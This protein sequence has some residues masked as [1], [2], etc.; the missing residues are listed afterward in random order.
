MGSLTEKKLT[1]WQKRIG[2]LKSAE[3][4]HGQ[5]FPF[6]P[7]FARDLSHFCLVFAIFTYFP[8]IFVSFLAIIQQFF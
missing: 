6:S 8:S 3:I 4:E 1:V 2:K 7:Y 5:H